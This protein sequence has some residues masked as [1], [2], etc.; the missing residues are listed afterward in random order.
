[1]PTTL[2]SYLSIIA[3]SFL[4]V[5]ALPGLPDKI[6]GVNLGSWLLIEPWMLPAG[7]I[8]YFDP[9][10]RTQVLQ[11]GNFA[12]A[13][14][15]TVDQKFKE[16][17]QTWFTQDDVNTLKAAG[18]NAV[19]IP[20][21]YWIVEPLVNRTSEFYAKGGLLELR[22]GLK[23]LKEAG[24]PVVLDHHALPGVASP[25][26]MFAGRCTGDAQFYTP[27]NYHRALVWTAVITAL[28]HLHPDFSIVASIQSLNEPIMDANLTPGLGEY[29]KNFAQI[30]RA[31]EIALGIPV[32]GIAIG[33]SANLA[34]A[35]NVTAA[36]SQAA[37]LSSIFNPEVRRALRD[38]IPMILYAANQLG[39]N[40]IFGLD[41]LRNLLRKRQ[42]LVANFMNAQWQYNNPSNPADGA[43]GPTAYDNHLYYS[44]GGVADANEEAY[45]KHLCN[46]NRIEE[47][48]AIGNSPLWF[49]EWS[50]ATQFAATDEFLKKWA[51]AQK[52]MYGKGAGYFFW[53]FKIEEGTDTIRQWSYL[54]GLKRGYLTQ[55]PS[56]F[57][58][59]HVCDAYV[60]NLT[61][62]SS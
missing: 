22:R 47:A 24:I 28:S 42:P 29:N 11:N 9:T 3:T 19:R 33:I 41:G 51:D 5:N 53:N 35:A 43:I 18:I 46:L 60:A 59:P 17:W 50:L 4:A 57:H 27:Y 49:G 14:P 54:E 25:N 39:M 6:H 10:T 52:L 34:S 37:S 55:D 61:A 2:F 31:V 8:L 56:Q 30:I 38:A 26:Q 62:T 23:Q 48:A 58:D 1:M 40:T 16:H 7:T 12:Q 36:V 44:F 21:G 13:Y 20:L 45:L 15:D 32:P